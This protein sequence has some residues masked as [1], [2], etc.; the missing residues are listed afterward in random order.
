MYDNVT[1]VFAWLAAHPG[2]AAACGLET[3]YSIYGNYADDIS[4]LSTGVRIGF[5]PGFGGSVAS[6]GTL[7]DPNI[8]A[9]LGQ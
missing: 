3:K 5:N 9:S 2:A 6:D 1:T 7:F 8:V 4:F